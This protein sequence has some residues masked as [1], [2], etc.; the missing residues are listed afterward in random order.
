MICPA[1]KVKVCQGF[2]VHLCI[3]SLLHWEWRAEDAS[4]DD[5]HVDSYVIR[6]PVTL[7]SVA[8]PS[9]PHSS[10]SH[11][12]PCG[13]DWDVLDMEE[14]VR[15][16]CK[17]IPCIEVLL[18]NA[19]HGRQRGWSM[20]LCPKGWLPH[21]TFQSMHTGTI[22]ACLED[23]RRTLWRVGSCYLGTDV[24]ASTGGIGRRPWASI[25]LQCRDAENRIVAVEAVN[26]TDRS[27]TKEKQR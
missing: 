23:P 24:G 22:W 18:Q 10:G 19:L 2:V 17:S 14:Q 7:A 5:C 20:E 13:V 6:L 11:H 12:L 27:T 25:A 3:T 4:R 15:N 8:D 21:T 1:L 26:R 16:D 9:H